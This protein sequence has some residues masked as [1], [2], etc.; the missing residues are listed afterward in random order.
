MKTA[1]LKIYFLISIFFFRL[2]FSFGQDPVKTLADN[3]ANSYLKE[4]HNTG[5]MVIGLYDNGTERIYYY[6][7]TEKGNNQKPDSNSLYEIGNI[8]ETFTSILFADRTW[9]GVMHIDDKLQDYLPIDVPAIVYQPVVCRPVEQ[10]E[11]PDYGNREGKF[12]V[13]FTPYVCTPDTTYKA[14]PIILCYLASHTS[15][16]PDFPDNLHSKNK[17]N[18]YSNY[19][20]ENLYEFLRKFQL[21]N[22]IGFDYKYSHLGIAILGK[23][24]SLKMKM[25]FE[26]ALK[27]FI[28]DSL[29]MNDTRIS[30]NDQELKRRVSGYNQK[31]IKAEYWSA[32]VFAPVIGLHSS[33]SDMMK[34]LQSNIS[35]KKNYYVD[36]LDYTHN[37]RIKPGKLLDDDIEI[38]L[39]WKIST[40]KSSENK[41][42]WQDGTTGGFASFIGFDET[43][44]KGAFILSSTSKKVEGMGKQ[45]LELMEREKLK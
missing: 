25:P 30:W 4:N 40:L 23:T 24:V 21:E 3:L 27:E 28:L 11:A 31:G 39:G 13:V 7:E 19:N 2:A 38:A 37:P 16:L 20:T 15:G 42:V 29:K 43:T 18:P 12:G 26:Q 1:N 36:L 34:F 5:S 32:D 10:K 41:I 44:H 8:S 33:P 17:S 35:I 22:Q 45:I 6:G 14:Q 9:K